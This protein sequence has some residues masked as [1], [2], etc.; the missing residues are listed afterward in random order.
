[1]STIIRIITDNYVFGGDFR[2]EHGFSALVEDDG[3]RII[4]D[5]GK[6]G[7]V[8]RH[9]FQLTGVEAESIE[10][11]VIS[12]GHYDHTGG[13]AEL[14]KLRHSALKIFAHPEIFSNRFAVDPGGNRRYI[15][16]YWSKQYLEGLGARFQFITNPTRITPNV[17]VSGPIPRDLG[18]EGRSPRFKKLENGS[19]VEDTIPDDQAL[20]VITEEG[21]VVIVGCCHAGLLNTVDYAVKLT[22]VERIR[23]V[24]GGTHLAGYDLSS[25]KKLFDE[26]EKFSIEEFRLSHCTGLIPFA[27]L[28][29]KFPGRVKP[30]RAGDVIKIG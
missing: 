7:E 22:G 12:H 6:T 2:A 3:R 9:N 5:F 13:V 14:L 24:I 17:W 23:L 21:L 8:F 29:R 19:L 28:Y 16:I 27:E 18:F 20:Y 15:G 25:L 1:M 11:G 10:A 4:F 30:T 26:L